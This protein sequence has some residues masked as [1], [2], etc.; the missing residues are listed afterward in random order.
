MGGSVVM[1][2]HRHE[3]PTHLDV[4]DKLLLGLTVR[5]VLIVMLGCAI[6]Y[7]LW[8]AF[9]Q[10]QWPTMLRFIFSV[11]PACVSVALAVL[12]PVGRTLELWVIIWLRYQAQA[13]VYT[14]RPVPADRADALAVE[15]PSRLDTPV[16]IP[17]GLAKGRG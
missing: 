8:H 1:D 5:Q 17:D 15:D 12:K 7:L 11:I 3:I 10:A 6:G 2:L 9:G 14:W 13:R 16:I 4:E